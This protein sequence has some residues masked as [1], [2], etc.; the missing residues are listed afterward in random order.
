MLCPG[1]P[2]YLVSVLELLQV[3]ILDVVDE[4]GAQWET[5]LTIQRKGRD[6]GRLA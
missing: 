6:L 4:P 3:L 2:L 5:S 1:S